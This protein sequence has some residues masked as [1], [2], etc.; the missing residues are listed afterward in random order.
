MMTPA[1]AGGGYG[2]FRGRV[3]NGARPLPLISL[4]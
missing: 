2:E 4:E 1:E 3:R